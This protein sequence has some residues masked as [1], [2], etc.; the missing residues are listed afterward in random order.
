MLGMGE[1]GHTASLFPHTAGLRVKGRLVIANY[2]PEK[3]TWRMTFTYECING[4]HH[5]A[6]YVLGASKRLMLT[7]VLTSIEHF[8]RY[9][10]Q[11]VGT[12]THPVLW[13]AD[14]DAADGLIDKKPFIK[15]PS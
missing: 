11:K 2:I 15:G 6:I 5:T 4:A 12:L 3:N 10:I 1:D 8:D 13:I 7:E 9:P 14:Q